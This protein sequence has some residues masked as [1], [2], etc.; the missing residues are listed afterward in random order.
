MNMIAAILLV[1]TTPFATADRQVEDFPPDIAV[2]EVSEKQLNAA[3]VPPSLRVTRSRSD[4][5]RWTCEFTFR[6]DRPANSVHLAGDFNGWNPKAT[7]MTLMGDGRFR[8]SIELDEG[9]RYYKFVVDE[10][11]WR[12]DPLNP[13]RVN[14]GH[15]SANSMLSLGPEAGLNA[16]RGRQGDE[17]IEAA[18]LKH[19]PSRPI[20]R[21]ALPDGR[22]LLR[23]RTLRGDST[24]A[25]LSVEHLGS[26][27]MQLA[28]S[29]ETFDF[30]EVGVDD[31][32]DGHRYTF[33]VEDGE[34]KVR[35]DSVY[36]LE[37]PEEG[38]H[39]TP[40]WAKDAIWYQVM[41]DRFRNGIHDNDPLNSFPW[42]KQWYDSAEWEGRDGQTFYEWFVFDRMCGGDLQGLE[43]KLDYLTELGV[44]ALYLNPVFQADSC[45]KYNATNYLHVDDRY[46]TGDDYLRVEKEEDLLDPSSWQWTRSDEL[47][48]EFL[49]TAK[50]KGFR[51]IIDGV[52][53][54]VGTSHPAFRDVLINRSDS[55]YA[56]WF[57]VRS[58]D[59]F[60]YE[61]WA[62]FGGLPAFKKTDEGL[63]CE[64]VKQ[65]IFEITRRWMDPDGDGDPSD[66]IDGW[67]LD[68]PN[69]IAI[70]FW[71]DWCAHVRSINPDAYITGEIWDRA[72][73]WLDGRSFDAVMN[74]EFSKVVFDWVGAKQNKISASEADARL[75]SL[76]MAYPAEVNYVLQNLIDSHDTDRAVSKIHNPD[77]P[78]DSGNREQDDPTYDGSKPP[79]D[80]YRRLELLALIQMTY[81][82]A[83]MVYYG[84][85]VGMWGSDDPNNRKAMI[86]EDL[87]AYED[88]DATVMSDLLESYKQMIRLRKDHEALRRGSFETLM[89]DDEQDLFVYRRTHG[90][91]TLVIA[92]NAG[93]NEARFSLPD[94]EWKA[95]HGAGLSPG[96]VGPLSGRV[97]IK[98]R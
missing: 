13:N 44:N 71:V 54:H 6:P 95:I 38:S 78:F 18:A 1:G 2:A 28:N 9:K 37:Q 50:S 32:A 77:R 26:F 40:D 15:G 60:E 23:Y 24:G 20:Y 35:D 5:T 73:E 48:L 93:E 61:G 98:S 36:T 66:G 62:G 52:F 70:P 3:V 49:K 46:G 74:Y 30:W 33:I 97:W 75:A 88:P 19:D 11:S 29:D 41:V 67:R 89:T 87:G 47:F 65:H 63:E 12:Y 90:D 27:R 72:D 45:H 22:Y 76:R 81:I 10:S 25:L 56:D 79:E 80:A 42:K 43:Q 8:T 14:D 57:D 31:D 86:W 4:A 83:P 16:S 59:P 17:T 34:F 55:P 82:G 94:G 92:L 91:E 85:E 21:Q 7:P 39:R 96:V 58:W 69:E 64:A 53:N 84:S 68:V 51:V